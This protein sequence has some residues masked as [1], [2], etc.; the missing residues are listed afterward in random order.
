M[1]TRKFSKRLLSMVLALSMVVSTAVVIGMTGAAQE[2]QAPAFATSF[3][4]DAAAELANWEGNTDA[5][6]VADGKLTQT[7]GD[8]KA[9]TLKAGQETAPVYGD[10][11]IDATLSQSA[12]IVFRGES[13]WA[14]RFYVE[15]D[16]GGAVIVRNLAEAE[17]ASTG[18]ALTAG[19]PIDLS[20]RVIGKQIAVFVNGVKVLG[21]ANDT[22]PDAGVV[23]IVYPAGM[24]FDRFA[25]TPLTAAAA[26]VPFATG[27]NGAAANELANWDGDVAA[28]TVADGALTQ[29]TGGWK[30][31]TLNAGQAAPV[32]YGDVQINATLS[33]TGRIFFRG[34]SAWTNRYYLEVDF[35]GAVF[36]RNLA[37]ADVA[38]AGVALTAGTPATVKIVVVGKTVTVFVN[39]ELVLTHTDDAMPATG[40]VGMVYGQ[41][42]CFQNFSVAPAAAETDSFYTGFA[43]D[44]ATELANWSGNTDAFTVADSKLTQAAGSWTALTLGD[45]TAT[46]GDVSIEASMSQTGRIFFRG[47]S[48]WANRFYVEM[49]FGGAVFLRNLG[50]ENVASAAVAL[51]AGTPALVNITVI[52]QT[53]SVFVNGELVL[54][55]TDNTLPATG[56][57]G[58]VFGCGMVFDNFGVTVIP[59]DTDDEG[60]ENPPPSGDGDEGGEN[61]PPVGGDDDEEGEDAPPAPILPILPEENIFHYF[62][63]FD[64]VDTFE[65]DWI[66]TTAMELVA[67]NL[68][69]YHDAIS[70]TLLYGPDD[71]NYMD[72]YY[73]DNYEIEAVFGQDARIAFRIKEPSVWHSE[74]YYV[75]VQF[76]PQASGEG[77]VLLRDKLEDGDVAK[78]IIP[79]GVLVK[80]T[81]VRVRV[82]VVGDTVSVFLGNSDEAVLTYDELEVYEGYVGLMSIYSP[83]EFRW[84][85]MTMLD[86]EGNP[87]EIEVDDNTGDDNTGDDNTGDDNTGDDNTGDDNTGDDNT[88]ND[89]ESPDTGDASGVAAMMAVV[90]AAGAAIV[91]LRK[92]E[93]AR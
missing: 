23:G 45:G 34:E 58:V 31:I 32:T 87:I 77:V 68:I 83:V 69:G 12:R 28:F 16:F 36:L 3:D 86:E 89:D 10:V 55:H 56:A 50:E 42:M 80:G 71:D 52:D 91:V 41:G 75:E 17:I 21:V 61:P 8:W 39:G 44:Q 35:G 57:I 13:P 74:R 53:V 43:G 93:S 60:G 63:D 51:T 15:V 5:F 40:Y 24:V 7:A 81:D 47:E 72:G 38:S 78:A 22:L 76:N 73:F 19:T 59:T 84:F 67:G 1:K 54:T 18:V 49:D 27:F 29:I 64:D 9:L 4:G 25:V 2:P 90:L 11:Q 14:N 46:Y 20:I 92:R 79:A 66:G 88:G 26:D 6:T 48:A 70:G 85:L 37:E 82:R 65:Y 30:A 33:Q 62:D